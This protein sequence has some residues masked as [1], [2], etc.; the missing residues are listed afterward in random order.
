MLTIN[1]VVFPDQDTALHVHSAMCE[2]LNLPNEETKTY[3]VFDIISTMN[4]N[5]P[6]CV[7]FDS[8]II[9]NEFQRLT[10]EQLE[11]TGFVFSVRL[12]S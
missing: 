6:R 2:Q 12:G 9:S 4:G 10:R 7:T 8:P 1:Y 3:R 5:D 11:A